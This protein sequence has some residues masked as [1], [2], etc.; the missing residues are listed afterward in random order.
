MELSNAGTDRLLTALG[1][2]PEGA[3]PSRRA[4]AWRLRGQHPKYCEGQDIGIIGASTHAECRRELA[5]RQREGWTDLAI[6]PEA[7][8]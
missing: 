1:V 3:Q 8:P 2:E 4:Y 5:R 6:V 7:R